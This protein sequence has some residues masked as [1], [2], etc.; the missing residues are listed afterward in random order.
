MKT[1]NIIGENYLGRW[2]KAR[3]ACRGIVLRGNEIL[4][5]YETLD[6]QWMLPG[7]GLEE[8]EEERI[9]CALEIAEETGVLAEPSACALEINEYYRDRKWVNR[10]FLCRAVGSAQPRLTERE[11][12]AGMEPRWL[13]L[14]E[15]KSIFAQYP[16]YTGL[17][18]MRRGLYLR[19]YTALNELVKRGDHE[20][21]GSL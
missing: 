20:P 11:R 2:K 10:Y 18:E 7:G 3:V 6:D 14:E 13:P 5:S 8:G 16:R 21:V 4:L 1:I 9:C 17:D 12:A 15:V 19:E